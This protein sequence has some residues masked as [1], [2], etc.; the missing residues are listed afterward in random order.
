MPA[1]DFDVIIVG[2]GP[3]GSTA[4]ILLAQ[5]GR[6]V[7]LI[8]RDKFPRANTT[9]GWISAR[10]APFLDLLHVPTKAILND[11]FN[12]VTFLNADFT[13]S[14]QP[15]FA[16]SPGYLVDRTKFDKEIVSAAEKAGVKVHQGEPVN[17]LSLKES[18]VIAELGSG[19][20]I[21][22]RLLIL[23]TGA[24]SSLVE[25]VGVARP[26][27]ARPVW[28]A[29]I[30]AESKSKKAAGPHV[31][32]VLGLNK[33]GSFGLICTTSDRTTI[34]ISW[35]GEREG[36]IAALV[37][38]CRLAHQHEQVP[39]DLSPQASKAV[40]IATPGSAALEMDTHVGKHALVIGDAGGFV[41]AA[42][43]EGIY[44]AMWSG[45]IA[46][47]VIDA[48]LKSPHSQDILMTFNSEWRLKMAD[49]L[50]SPNTDIQFLLPLIFSNQAMADRM[51]GAFFSGEN[52]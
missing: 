11:A 28:M 7:A 35:K 39:I 49:Y 47:Q 22:A 44:P 33:A 52:I 20:S 45:Q 16:E 32:V 23:A 29:S 6:N 41:A 40:V 25:A 37:N 48:A 1:T 12:S 10:T 50:R 31:A 24:A 38:I 46:A 9:V 43:H 51:G 17:K 18:S 5:A 13:K 42:S 36:A 8:D 3:A 15:S 2:A 4:A 19:K 14:S 34:N 27:G 21:S 26:R 30:D